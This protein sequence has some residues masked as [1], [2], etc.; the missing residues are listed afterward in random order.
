[1]TLWSRLKTC[2]R[3][4]LVGAWCAAG[5]DMS[6]IMVTSPQKRCLVLPNL[7][8][9]GRIAAMA[10]AITKNSSLL[11]STTIAPL[12]LL[13]RCLLFDPGVVIFLRL[14]FEIRL[15]VVMPKAA[16]LGADDLIFAN[17]RGG[18]MDRHIQS[19]DKV[20]LNAQLRNKE[21]MSHILGMHEHVNLAV[22]RN[23]HLRGDDIVFRILIVRGIQTEKVGIGFADLFG[24]NRA[25]LSVG[26]GIAEIKSEL[27]G[28]DLHRYRIGSRRSEIHAG[29]CL[30][31][32]HT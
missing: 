9:K 26:A 15:H 12:L 8:A 22:H 25:E 10:K 3:M 24:M 1:M 17:F 27:T 6:C 21:G 2:F 5:A 28:L 19:R 23:R 32:E 31:T 16:E 11:L 30:C 20:L 14:H 29:P 7:V 13:Q 4:K 18:E